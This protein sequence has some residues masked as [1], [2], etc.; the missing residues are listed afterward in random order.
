MSQWR[1]EL[2]LIQQLAADNLCFCA[3][4]RRKWTTPL[5]EKRVKYILSKQPEGR[6]PLCGPDLT[7]IHFQR[8]AEPADTGRDG[9]S[10]AS[11]IVHSPPSL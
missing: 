4:Q 2:T 3:A 9:Q 8:C 11:T 5:R 6:K 10:P 7:L 1:N